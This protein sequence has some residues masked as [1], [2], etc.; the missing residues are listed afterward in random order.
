MEQQFKKKR[1]LLIFAGILL[2]YAFYLVS[3]HIPMERHVIH[4]PLD[5]MIPFCEVFVIPYVWWYGFISGPLVWF[6]VKSREDFLDLGIYLLMGMW[7]CTIFFFVYPTCIDFL[8]QEFP[9][10]N[11]FTFLT[12]RLYAADEPANVFPSI[13][14]FESVAICIAI[15]KSKRWGNHR[16]PRMVGLLSAVFICLST[17]FIK[18]HSV[19]DAAAG[20][21]LAF[22]LYIPVYKINWPYRKRFE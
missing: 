15:W 19:L 5:D 4:V 21:L 10:E 17:L 9:R 12:G 16:K 22:I 11:F 18:Q 2:A 7:F 8:P 14:C 13:H 20:V 3:V 6:F 1:D